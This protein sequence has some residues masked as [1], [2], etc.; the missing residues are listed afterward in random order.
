MNH[1][2]PLICNVCTPLVPQNYNWLI[3][4]QTYFLHRKVAFDRF[5]KIERFE[6]YPEFATPD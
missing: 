3:M 6:F 4:S 2:L 1:K 5:H